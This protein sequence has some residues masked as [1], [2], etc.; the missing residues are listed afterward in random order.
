MRVATKRSVT[1]QRNGGSAIF[2]MRTP[3]VSKLPHEF[4]I[5]AKQLRS[6]GSE[7]ERIR[8]RWVME[9]NCRLNNHRLNFVNFY[10][11]LLHYHYPF[12]NM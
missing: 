5:P 7:T 9:C 10:C 12:E 2:L 6:F 1:P 4:T 11:T 8:E 3:E